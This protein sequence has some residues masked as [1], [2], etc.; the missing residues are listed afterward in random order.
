MTAQGPI[1]RVALESGRWV[2]AAVLLA[3]IGGAGAASAAEQYELS[4]DASDPRIFKVEAQL[5]VSGKLFPQPGP[6]KALKLAVK[7]RFVFDERRREGT[8]REAQTLRSVRHYEQARAS[9][10]AGTQQTNYE[11]RDSLRLV[12]AQGS[13]EGIE[14]FSPLGPLTFDE[15]ELL[16]TPGDCLAM[17][18]LLPDSKVELG[19]SWQPADWVMPLLTGIEA[20]EKSSLKCQLEAVTGPAARVSVSGTITG[21][22]AGA[23]ATIA[24]DGHFVYDL[25]QKHVRQIELTQ[26]EKRSIGTVS[27]GLDV[28]ARVEL[29]RKVN[30]RPQR[31]TDRNLASVPLDA[32]DAN[33]LLMFDAPA[34]NVRFY[35][36]RHWHLFH[37]NSEAAILRLLD[38]GGLIAQCNIKRLP[39]AEPGRHMDETEFKADIERTLGKDFQEFAQTDA[40]RLR[41]DLFVYR[42]VAVGSVTRSNE[43]NE[44][45][46]TPMQWHYYLVANPEGRQLAFVFTVDPRQSENFES[47]D[48]SIVGGLEFLAPPETLKSA[49]K[50]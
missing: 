8:G 31:L 20:A 24:V 37:Q 22:V 15:L 34:W 13:S 42:A 19:E 38:K 28:T 12:V 11:L 1:T 44:P 30:A 46:T 45:T 33:R 49:K 32:N 3:A 35:H 4:E 6:D 36:D 40:P 48:L 50:P 9:I 27:P 5:D 2:V 26:T 16:R 43:K 21:A 39:D 25:E 14:L 10:E 29:T 41:K 23:P 7:G 17:Q 47:R 18:A